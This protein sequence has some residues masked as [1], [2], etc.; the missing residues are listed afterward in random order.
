MQRKYFGEFRLASSRSENVTSYS[1]FM[2]INIL[3]PV[4]STW[5]LIRF[6]FIR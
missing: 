5:R 4:K 3:G 2:Q 6:H 1:Q